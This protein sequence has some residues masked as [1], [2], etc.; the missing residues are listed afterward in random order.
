MTA[1]RSHVGGG[2]VVVLP[3][4]AGVRGFPGGARRF[5][6][7]RWIVETLAVVLAALLVGAAAVYGLSG[8]SARLPRQPAAMPHDVVRCEPPASSDLFEACR[9]PEQPI[10]ER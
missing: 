4:A 7:E 1:V 2:R 3:A 10:G 8:A 9:T 6:P 5:L